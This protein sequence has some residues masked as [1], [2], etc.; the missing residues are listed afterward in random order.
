MGID[1][2]HRQ[3]AAAILAADLA[4]VEDTASFVRSFVAALP[5]DSAALSPALA[6]DLQGWILRGFDRVHEGVTQAV[7]I[8]GQA[9]AM[10]DA[11][12]ARL[13][14]EA[15]RRTWPDGLNLSA[16]LWTWQSATRRGVSDVL[17]KGIRQMQGVSATIYD[18]Q[19]AI[20]A[21]TGSRFEIANARQKY[22]VDD[23]GRSAL[24]LI[25]DPKAKQQW[26]KT[27]SE[28]RGHINGL[29]ENG[30]RAAAERAFAQITQAAAKG[31]AELVASAMHWFV[32]D[33]QLYNIKRIVRTEMATAGH[34]AIID[35][36][37]HD[38]SIIGYQW[39]LSASHP[40]PDIC[41]YY[42]SIDMGLGRGVWTPEA[43][44]RQKAHPHC[45]CLIVP[46][47]TPV[48][49]KGSTDYASFIKG[50][51]PKRRAQLLPMWAQ[52]AIADGTPLEQLI[53]PDGFGLVAQ[54]SI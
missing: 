8:G 2:I 14:D 7:Q 33:R 42:A 18:M 50:V 53:R 10:T 27:V 12:A 43:V 49:A 45:M 37:I 3:L 24:G 34:N 1:N 47:V 26:L 17:G 51:S 36:T 21:T 5:A 11:L 48:R 22:W 39:R 13:A 23:L 30:T 40:E 35:S 44:P 28:I 32:Y 54:P 46:R 25:H 29:A 15:Y 16:R 31:N 4:E 41:D 6:A 19:R 52:K 9:G 38:S 20:E